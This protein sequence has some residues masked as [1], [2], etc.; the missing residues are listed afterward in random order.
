M[1]D[2]NNEDKRTL[3]GCIMYYNNDYSHKKNSDTKLE[4]E[5]KYMGNTYP[6]SLVLKQNLEEY[7]V[8]DH[9]CRLRQEKNGGRRNWNLRAR[10]KINQDFDP[11]IMTY[12]LT[13]N[14]GFIDD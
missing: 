7:Y 10:V 8:L 9:S 13:E 4:F 14:I 1:E 6:I 12:E 5:A 11:K 3:E 2:K